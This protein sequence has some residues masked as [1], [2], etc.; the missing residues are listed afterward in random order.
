MVYNDYTSTFVDI[1][2]K[3]NTV[4][5]HER[6]R[7]VLAIERCKIPHNLA[8]TF[9]RDIMINLDVNHCTR[10]TWKATIDENDIM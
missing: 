1:L 8:P 9:I 2:I 6:N 5:I 7:R 3:D 4:T 10:Y